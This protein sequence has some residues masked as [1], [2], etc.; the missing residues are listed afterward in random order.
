MF[1]ILSGV[2]RIRPRSAAGI[3]G[4]ILIFS[5]AAICTIQVSSFAAQDARPSQI[6]FTN[7]TA[8]AGIK[9]KHF[10]G[11]NGVSINLE[12]FGPGV[13][14]T[15]FDGDG[16]QDIYF[17]NGRDLYGRGISVVNAL[18]RNNHDGTFT[19]PVAR[20]TGSTFRYLLGWHT[21]GTRL[22]VFEPWAEAVPK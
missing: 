1:R 21:T 13:C 10:K 20:H 15:D 11:N 6:Q 19:W 16:W 7:V 3:F 4:G 22:P 8:T 2:S 5:L 14:V 17:V 12:E 18:Y 9:F